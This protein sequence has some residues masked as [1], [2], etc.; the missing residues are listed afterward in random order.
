MKKSQK[1]LIL[2]MCLIITVLCCSCGNKN[3][4]SKTSNKT[5]VETLENGQYTVLDVRETLGGNNMVKYFFVSIVLKDS[6]NIQHY[7]DYQ[8]D[9]NKDSTYIS[10]ATLVPNNKVEYENKEFKIITEDT[11][12]INIIHTHFL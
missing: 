4:K 6:N 11:K 12:I 9:Y 1:K 10:L 2:I 8:C 7:Y 5:D 3:E